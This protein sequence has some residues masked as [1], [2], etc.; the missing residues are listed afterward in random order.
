MKDGAILCNAGHFDVEV[1]VRRLSEIAVE[2]REM[3]KNIMGYRLKNGRWLHVLGEGRLVNLAAG[4][5]HPVEIMDMSFGIQAL[6]A[7][8]IAEHRGA[9][10]PKLHDVPAEIDREVAGRKLEALGV[11]IDELTS[12][13]KAYLESWE[14]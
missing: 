6:C 2:Q 9:L 10:A 11:R 4:D 14:A 7:R 12:E 3:R 8:Y 13:Q 1:N 5:G